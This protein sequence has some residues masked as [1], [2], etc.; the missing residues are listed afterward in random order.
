MVENKSKKINI[1][2]LCVPWIVNRSLLEGK[3]IIM[4][5]NHYLVR[6]EIKK[7][8]VSR[9]LIS[10]NAFEPVLLCNDNEKFVV[11][12]D[13]SEFPKFHKALRK[14][15]EYIEDLEVEEYRK[16]QYKIFLNRK[17]PIY[18]ITEKMALRSLREEKRECPSFFSKGVRKEDLLKN[19]IEELRDIYK[20][21]NGFYIGDE[22]QIFS[23][24]EQS[25]AQK[26]FDNEYQN[27][28]LTNLADHAKIIGRE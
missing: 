3:D 5:H 15:A 28:K 14:K 7:E 6:R 13:G 8:L 22:V 12:N 18:E 21:S 10:K 17:R 9:K 24:K 16:K 11:Y 23:V 26:E 2:M 19:A 1:Q 20:I 4:I 25:C 27:E